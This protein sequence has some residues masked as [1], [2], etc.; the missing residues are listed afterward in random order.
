MARLPL[1]HAIVSGVSPPTTTGARVSCKSS[2]QLQG[3][4][5]GIER[6]NEA[7]PRLA[8][9]S[10]RA[11]MCK[12]K[13]RGGA[14]ERSRAAVVH[15]TADGEAE[16]VKGKCDVAGRHMWPNAR[17]SYL[18]G[19]GDAYGGSRGLR[20]GPLPADERPRPVGGDAQ[21]SKNA[22]GDDLN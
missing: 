8:S 1:E 4:S 10:T 14:K 11:Y 15:N 16:Y 13:R 12:R 18:A 21:Q 5:K 19:G 22:Q 6:S 9:M 3:A 2:Q 7:P 20:R 17:T